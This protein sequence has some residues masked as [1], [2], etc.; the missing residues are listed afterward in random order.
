MLA[1]PPHDGRKYTWGIWG[2]MAVI[3]I[4]PL[5]FPFDWDLLFTAFSRQRDGARR[6][7]L[8]IF[9]FTT[10]CVAPQA[11][12]LFSTQI[13]SFWNTVFLCRSA[14]FHFTF[15]HRF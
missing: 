11:C 3:T 5:S 15:L 14:G 2:R 9:L 7:F 10:A 12:Q 13:P 8:L 1:V 4:N 6:D